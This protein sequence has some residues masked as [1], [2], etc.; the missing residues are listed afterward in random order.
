MSNE[1]TNEI[2]ENVLLKES[3]YDYRY[4]TLVSY[5]CS[6]TDSSVENSCEEWCEN[7]AS[8]LFDCNAEYIGSSMMRAAINARCENAQRL[9]L[10]IYHS[11]ASSCVFNQVESIGYN[12]EVLEESVDLSLGYY[13]FELEA[14][15]TTGNHVI[16]EIDADMML[17]NSC[18]YLGCYT[19]SC[20]CSNCKALLPQ[21][22]SYCKDVDDE[23]NLV[24]AVG[25]T[26]PGAATTFINVYS[27]GTSIPIYSIDSSN[28]LVSGKIENLAEGT[29][30][31][32]SIAVAPSG[33]ARRVKRKTIEVSYECSRCHDTGWID[34]S[35][36]CS[37]CTAYLNKVAPVVIECSA[38][39]ASVSAI[40]VSINASCK[41]AVSMQLNIY[42]GNSS[43]SMYNASVYDSHIERL[44]TYLLPGVYNIEVK[45]IIANGE[46]R[47]EK[48][49]GNWDYDCTMCLD[50][51]WLSN[52]RNCSYCE[53]WRTNLAPI[54]GTC[55]YTSSN[56]SMADLSIVAHCQNAD[57]MTVSVY[58]EGSTGTVWSSSSSSNALTT[59]RSDVCAGKYVVVVW[60]H[61]NSGVTD[62]KQ[63]EMT[64]KENSADSFSI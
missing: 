39:S 56:S 10:N 7:I 41:N 42:S 11:T 5:D 55:S 34:R 44:I 58:G 50:T 17:S 38:E 51:G 33:A 23:G 3:T 25:A 14:T 36:S 22:I 9:H 54:H 18:S 60:A 32:E 53:A 13:K 27:Q 30:I 64:V 63:I 47:V 1:K 61:L 40:N 28:R 31:I 37:L 52:S 8:I 46:E 45:A 57:S 19:T 43:V 6:C 24:L 2:Y 48:I 26:S 15:L 35:M 49:V 4:Y 16:K 29:Y 59:M 12:G 20:N 21:S 62:S